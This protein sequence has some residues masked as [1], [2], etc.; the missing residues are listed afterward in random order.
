M[1]EV[2]VGWELNHILEGTSSCDGSKPI[3][4]LF[5]NV[6]PCQVH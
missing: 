1:N 4:R 5:P 6:Y 2:G 3:V